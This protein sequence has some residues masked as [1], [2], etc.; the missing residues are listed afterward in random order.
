MWIFRT[1]FTKLFNRGHYQ[2]STQRIK[3]VLL[4]VISTSAPTRTV[5]RRASSFH[6][7]PGVNSLSYPTHQI[8]LCRARF[9]IWHI[10]W[11][12][13]GIINKWK[14]RENDDNP[15]KLIFSID[16]SHQVG[17]D[18]CQKTDEYFCWLG[19]TQLIQVAEA[20]KNWW[21]NLPSANQQCKEH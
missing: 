18:P 5:V 14:S 11:L 15:T 2:H 1:I 13:S 17:V 9:S 19:K 8:D 10:N 16:S 12:L 20:A 21:E 4:N 3:R 6:R 7:L